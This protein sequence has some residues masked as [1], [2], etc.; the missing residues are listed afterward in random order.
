MATQA[1][2]QADLL[3]QQQTLIKQQQD[4]MDM[5]VRI[6]VQLGITPPAGGEDGGE[7]PLLKKGARHA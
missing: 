1:E 5:L 2:M 6:E 3:A 7:T 4:M